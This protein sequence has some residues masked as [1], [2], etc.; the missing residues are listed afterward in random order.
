ME[1]APGVGEPVDEA[2]HLSAV[3]HL[4]ARSRSVRGRADVDGESADAID[5]SEPFLVAF[6]RSN[7]DGKRAAE[8]DEQAQRRES[9]A[10]ALRRCLEAARRPPQLQALARR[11]PG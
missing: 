9:E 6:A 8:A 10:G 11:E 3:R 5:G 4:E 7:V 2:D 1:A